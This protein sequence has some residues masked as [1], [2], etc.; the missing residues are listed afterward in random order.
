[1]CFEL[2]EYW[3]DPNEADIRDAILVHCDMDNKATCVFPSPSR[4]PEINYI[5]DKTEIWLEDFEKGIKVSHQDSLLEKKILMQ[6]YFYVQMNYK[7]DS[8]QIGFLQLLSVS[9]SQNITYHCKNSVAYFD[10]GHR[11]YRKGLK[12]L[13]WNDAE[14]LPRSNNQRLQYKVG[15][16][17]CRVRI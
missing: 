14:I 16:D 17:E 4:S 12:L 7:A 10:A 2:G 9:A 1:M 13:T 3:V 11:N 8:N 6:P 15:E 5:G